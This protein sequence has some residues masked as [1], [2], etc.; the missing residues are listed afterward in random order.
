[1]EKNNKLSRGQEYELEHRSKT[2]KDLRW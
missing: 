2:I 1:M